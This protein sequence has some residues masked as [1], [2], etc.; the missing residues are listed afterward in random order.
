MEA[1]V[2]GL[3]ETWGGGGAPPLQVSSQAQQHA[4]GLNFYSSTGLT[5]YGNA[6]LSHYDK[7][8]CEFL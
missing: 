5:I 1:W 4:I 6:G 8:W 2:R 3:A 7:A